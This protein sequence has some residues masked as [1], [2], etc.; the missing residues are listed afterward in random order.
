MLEFLLKQ[1]R[2]SLWKKT[3]ITETINKFVNKRQAGQTVGFKHS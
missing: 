1:L 2:M 3:A